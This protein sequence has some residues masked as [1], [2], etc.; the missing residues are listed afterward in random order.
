MS[1]LVLVFFLVM[2]F[3]I[4]WGARNGFFQAEASQRRSVRD[5]AVMREAERSQ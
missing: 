1:G 3:I 2:A 4:G 5:D